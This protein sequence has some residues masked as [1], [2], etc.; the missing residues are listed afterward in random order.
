MA[1]INLKSIGRDEHIVTVNGKQRSF[2]K[3]IYA[4]MYIREVKGI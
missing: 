1:I 2:A 3:L 4:L